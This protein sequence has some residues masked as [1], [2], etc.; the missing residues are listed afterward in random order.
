MSIITYLPFVTVHV[1]KLTWIWS[2]SLFFR[3]SRT[4]DFFTSLLLSV[5][6]LSQHLMKKKERKKGVGLLETWAGPDKII[7]A[8]WAF[9]SI[10]K[11]NLDCSGVK[12]DWDP[13]PWLRG[14]MVSWI[15]PF[16]AEANAAGHLKFPRPFALAI[17]NLRICT[18]VR[19]RC[20][21]SPCPI[22]AAMAAAVATIPR[23]FS[24]F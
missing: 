14:S 17:S 20:W 21:W 11:P 10:F 15:F 23:S 13:P 8:L 1:K 12:L 4:S 18:A 24:M 22:A 3:L 5:E 7:F 16:A 6:G 2:G 19:R 9:I